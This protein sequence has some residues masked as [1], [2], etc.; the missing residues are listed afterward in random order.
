LIEKKL[1][2][3]KDGII[4]NF[5]QNPFAVVLLTPMMKRQTQSKK[6]NTIKQDGVIQISEIE[7]KVTTS[8][9]KTYEINTSVGICSCFE[10]QFGSFCTH[11]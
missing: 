1:V 8:D 7:Y 10:G 6:A 2:Y 3:E 5:K 4:V 9:D 11:Q